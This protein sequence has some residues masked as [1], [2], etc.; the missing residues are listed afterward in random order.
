MDASFLS[1]VDREM[2]GPIQGMAGG[3]S[4]PP[5]NLL[6]DESIGHGFCP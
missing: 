1:I 4:H 3:V 5:E 6:Y 2:G